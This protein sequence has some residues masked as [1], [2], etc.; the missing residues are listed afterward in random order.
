MKPIN[1]LR[2]ELNYLRERVLQLEKSK[3]HSSDDSSSIASNH[4]PVARDIVKPRL[5]DLQ[6]CTQRNVL[7]TTPLLPPETVQQL[8][9]PLSA[10]NVL[11]SPTTNLISSVTPIAALVE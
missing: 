10:H 5:T 6:V 4:L 7:A 9:Q 8:K 11:D 3:S 2:K 1:D